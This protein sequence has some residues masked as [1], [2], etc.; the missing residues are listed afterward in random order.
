M[1]WVVYACLGLGLAAALVGG[2]FQSF[3]DFVM[4][5]LI[6]A[7]PAGGMESMQQLNRTVFRSVFLVT[8]LALVPATAAFAIYAGVSLS[9]PPRALII[10]SAVVYVLLV[11]VVTAR[12]NV[13]MNERLDSLAHTS[14]EGHAY[15][16]T[17]GRAWT[18]WNHVRTLGSIAT[19]AC[20]LLAS[21]Q[22][23]ARSHEGASSTGQASVH[24]THPSSP[25]ASQVE[26][27]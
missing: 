23:A 2:V 9:G 12:G 21:V 17:Y 18:R 5:G 1:S 7:E 16:A 11:F 14:E 24:E 27:Y 26:R 6:L 15:W 10:S 20:L 25:Q 3:S 19:A 22:L 8:F 13:P 4:R